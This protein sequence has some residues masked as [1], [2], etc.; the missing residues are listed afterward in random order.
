MQSVCTDG[1]KKRERLH[2][3]VW[4]GEISGG[5]DLGASLSEHG[6]K[7]GDGYSVKVAP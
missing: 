4:S 5:S 3:V 2:F 1:V 6:E 7:A